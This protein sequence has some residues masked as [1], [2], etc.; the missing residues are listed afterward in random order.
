MGISKHLG[1]K[2]K[3]NKVQEAV[4]FFDGPG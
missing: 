3:K 2:K 4:S 1:C